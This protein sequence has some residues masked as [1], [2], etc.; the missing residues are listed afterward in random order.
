[1]SEEHLRKEDHAWGA[2]DVVAC[3]R[4]RKSEYPAPHPQ[5]IPYVEELSK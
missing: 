5:T 2:E 4:C 3:A 1:M